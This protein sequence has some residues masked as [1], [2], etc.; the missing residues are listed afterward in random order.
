MDTGALAAFPLVTRSMNRETS[1]RILD[2]I[3]GHNLRFQNFA[4]SVQGRGQATEEPYCLECGEQL[5]SP[6]HKLFECT[7]AGTVTA[8]RDQC[9]PL[10][11]CNANFHIP[12]IFTRNR[13]LK[14]KFRLLVSEVYDNLAFGDDLL[15]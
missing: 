9:L 2:F 13:N 11:V 1:T 8:L 12:L 15:A 3:H 5:D 6:Y 4:F 7:A 14:H 10:S